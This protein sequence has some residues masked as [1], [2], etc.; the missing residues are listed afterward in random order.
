MG[1]HPMNPTNVNLS[2][3]KNIVDVDTKG[4]ETLGIKGIDAYKYGISE[5]FMTEEYGHYVINCQ[6]N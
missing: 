6:I 3:T 2:G 5:R 4:D 1:K